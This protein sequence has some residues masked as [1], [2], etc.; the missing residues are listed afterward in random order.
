MNFESSNTMFCKLNG[1]FLFKIVQRFVNYNVHKF[2]Y[3]GFEITLNYFYLLCM[4]FHNHMQEFSRV[5]LVWSC[6]APALASDTATYNFFPCQGMSFILRTALV[7][8]GILIVSC[9]RNHLVSPPTAFGM[10]CH[11]IAISAILGVTCV[12]IPN[13]TYVNNN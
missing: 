1:Y 8:S 11:G 4:K 9:S 12:L 10:C 13:I 2:G 3:D 5:N 6:T 7:F